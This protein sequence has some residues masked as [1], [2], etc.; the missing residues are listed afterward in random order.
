MTDAEKLELKFYKNGSAEDVLKRYVFSEKEEKL[1]RDAIR[2]ANMAKPRMA[3]IHQAD[4]LLKEVA[5]NRQP[6]EP[7][8]KT[9]LSPE[10]LMNLEMQNFKQSKIEKRDDRLSFFYTPKTKLGRI[11]FFSMISFIVF[12]LITIQSR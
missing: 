11:I 12:M 5:K 6:I 2:T 9:E 10:T 4:E 3:L 7:T 1:V 8:E